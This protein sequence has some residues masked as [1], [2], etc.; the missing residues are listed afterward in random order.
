MPYAH[1]FTGV[2]PFARFG[3]AGPWTRI[4]IE[5]SLDGTAWTQ[6]DDQPIAL[7]GT[8]A[9]PDP[10][11]VTTETAALA[12]GLYRFRFADAESV[13]SPY[14]A[15]VVSPGSTS[16][17]TDWRPTVEEVAVLVGPYT[18]RGVG[19]YGE[20]AG[21][22]QGTFTDDTSP[23]RGQVV[24]FI[25]LAVIEIRGRANGIAEDEHDIARAAAT[26][27]AAALVVAHR[28]QAG[29]EGDGLY[30]AFIANYRANLDRLGGQGVASVAQ[31]TVRS[32]A[33]VTPVI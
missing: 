14:T 3:D 8:P 30:R 25:D 17:S 10:I 2:T 16:G 24:G 18:R 32:A 23:S 12:A 7:D 28:N 9:I 22:E 1:S 15:H 11:N 6:I 5:E 19:G 4:L 33:Y 20:H 31:I 29:V 13:L 26:W 21:Q 27:H